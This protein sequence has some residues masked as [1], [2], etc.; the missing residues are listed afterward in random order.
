VIVVADAGPILHLHWIGCSSWGLP[1]PL[2]HVVEQVW[3]EIARHAPVSLDDRRFVRTPSPAAYPFDPRR[4]S[5]HGGE[6]AAIAVAL[7][8][9]GALCL[10]FRLA[11]VGTIGL[12]LAA[13]RAGRV[14][15]IEARHAL[16]A[17]PARG[18]LH[19]APEL[20][21]RALLALPGD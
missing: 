1:Q 8:H 13:A 5:L 12:V 7:D 20:L 17:L 6:A 3:V 10:E 18:R 9:P 4:F 19:I 21:A 11:A 15:V 16:E 14:D 2:I